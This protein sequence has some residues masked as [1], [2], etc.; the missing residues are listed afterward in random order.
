MVEIRVSDLDIAALAS[1]G[2]RIQGDIT[3]TQ[4]IEAYLC[5]SLAEQHTPENRG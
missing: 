3:L 1:R 5:D 2:Y 4:V